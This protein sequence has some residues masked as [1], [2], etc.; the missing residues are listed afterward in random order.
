MPGDREYRSST[1]V[2]KSEELTI[3]APGGRGTA[4]GSWGDIVE[5]N[6]A[7]LSDHDW[8]VR[9]HAC[10][11][12]GAIGPA[13]AS[14]A[15]KPLA[16]ALVE[17]KSAVVRKA[18][19]E[20]LG[21]LG[22]GA[23]QRAGPPTALARALR[24][25]DKD[26][27]LAAANCLGVMGSPSI[28]HAAED[29]ALALKDRCYEVRVAAGKILGMVGSDTHP[30]A[31]AS[32]TLAL[33]DGPVGGVPRS[34][35]ARGKI[36]S[37]GAYADTLQGRTWDH[38]LKA[39]EEL[40]ALGSLSAPH[41]DHL[42]RTTLVD[43]NADVRREAARAIRSAGSAATSQISGIAA[44]VENPKSAQ[45]PKTTQDCLRSSGALGKPVVHERF[46]HGSWRTR[47]WAAEALSHMG[48]AADPY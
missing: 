3:G 22:P 6:I 26:V 9:W 2:H 28:P 34:V 33:R 13:A 17:D 14:V 32:L 5:T 8:R 35:A 24:D 43:H 36:H 30:Y 45:I 47:L 10:E 21:G 15:A 31:Q 16:I 46:R 12:L 48:S 37:A 27:R 42:V 38:R 44:V 11:N 40:R 19:A 7:R 25:P 1:G 4:N 23:A 41:T 39:A 20:A 29:L 18:A